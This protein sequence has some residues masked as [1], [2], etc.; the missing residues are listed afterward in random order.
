VTQTLV[1][2]GVAARDAAERERQA[3]EQ[4]VI[5]ALVTEIQGRAKT[6]TPLTLGM[7]VAWL[8]KAGIKR[9]PARELLDREH[10]QRWRLVQDTTRKGHPT[11][12]VS[13]TQEW[14][15]AEKRP[16]PEPRASRDTEKTLFSGPT[17]IGAGDKS[18]AESVGGDGVPGNGSSPR[19]APDV[20]PRN[21][22]GTPSEAVK[23][24]LSE[25]D[26]EEYL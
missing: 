16:S 23:P 21:K 8:V 9:D 26:E 13:P 20:P 14:P 11:F 19:R 3:A 5:G 22:P 1:E 12:V 25:A 6:N 2:A 24:A 15:F 17:V 10:G 7:A 4:A 18:H